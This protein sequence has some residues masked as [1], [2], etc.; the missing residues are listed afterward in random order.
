MSKLV[1]YEGNLGKFDYNPKEFEIDELVRYIGNETDGK[2]I[3]I[4][5]GVEDCGGMFFKCKSLTIAPD[6][7]EGV[8]NCS[9]MFFLCESLTIAPV[10]PEEVEDC[11]GMFYGCTSLRS[12]PAIPKGVEKCHKVFKGCTSLKMLMLFL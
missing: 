12:A 3:H 9:G 7:P 6:I 10:I 1:H 4:P 11:S 8:K 5:E 2:K